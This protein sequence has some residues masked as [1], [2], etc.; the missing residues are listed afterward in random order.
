MR[1]INPE[2][3]VHVGSVEVV[4]TA[5]DLARLDFGDGAAASVKSVANGFPG[6]SFNADPTIRRWSL[7]GT[8]CRSSSSRKG[9]LPLTRSGE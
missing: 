5:D 3:L 4:A 6:A 8:G 7:G 1:C 9:A 2:R